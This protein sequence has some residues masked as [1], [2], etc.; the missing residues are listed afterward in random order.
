MKVIDYTIVESG[1]DE[2]GKITTTQQ[3]VKKLLDAGWLLYGGPMIS[4]NIVKQAMIKFD[5]LKYDPDFMMDEETLAWKGKAEE[6]A[7]FMKLKGFTSLGP[8]T[9]NIN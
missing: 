9:I 3:E 4:G 8:V 5:P 6:V 2:Y 1:E 7:N